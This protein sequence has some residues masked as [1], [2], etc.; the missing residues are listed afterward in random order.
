MRTIDDVGT[1]V[2]TV[3]DDTGVK[4]GIQAAALRATR[5]AEASGLSG[6]EYAELY[7][8]YY[9]VIESALLRWVDGGKRI[10]IAI[11]LKEGT[12][13]VISKV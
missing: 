1:V 3:Q 7:T 13:E 5:N 4:M 11:N 12:A 10:Q 6:I 2:F 9:K 8:R